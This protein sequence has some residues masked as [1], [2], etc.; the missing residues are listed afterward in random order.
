MSV[1]KLDNKLMITGK[2]VQ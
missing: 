2:V 1:C